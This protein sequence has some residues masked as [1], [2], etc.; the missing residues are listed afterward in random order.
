MSYKTRPCSMALFDQGRRMVQI[1]ST[2]RSAARFAAR[3][4]NWRRNWKACGKNIP[5]YGTRGTG[6]RSRLEIAITMV[7]LNLL[8]LG[9]T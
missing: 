8:K 1:R 2:T 3:S 5:R 7:F 6:V 9:Y 4:R